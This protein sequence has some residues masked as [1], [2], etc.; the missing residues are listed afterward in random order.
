MKYEPTTPF[1][2]TDDGSL[3]YNLKQDGWRQGEP[4][5]VNDVWIAVNAPLEHHVQIAR[6]IMRELNGQFKPASII[7]NCEN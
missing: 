5:M 1:Y 6:T 7:E 2:M 4:R 3:V